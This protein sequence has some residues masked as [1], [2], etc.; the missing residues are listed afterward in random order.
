MIS[1][2][3]ATGTKQDLDKPRLGLVDSL[4]LWGL[5]RVLT[6]GA[7]KYSEHQWR[8]GIS[9]SRLY[10]ALQRHLT[11]WNAGEDTDP[12]SGLPHL[13]HAACE[14]MFLRWMSEHRTDL[15]DRYKYEKD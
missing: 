9:Y 3:A 11:A 1:T 7:N 15:D 14:L 13:D 6:F 8:G 4:F 12:E 10:N 5:A 2:Q